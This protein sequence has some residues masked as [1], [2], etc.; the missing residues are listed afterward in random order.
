DFQELWF[1]RLDKES[2]EKIGTFYLPKWLN[3]YIESRTQRGWVPAFR[4]DYG[5]MMDWAKKGWIQPSRNLICFLLPTFLYQNISSTHPT[6][7]ERN[8]QKLLQYPETLQKHIWFFFEEESDVYWNSYYLRFKDEKDAGWLNAFVELTK[9]GHIPRERLLKSCLTATQLNVNQRLVNWYI[10]L[11]SALKPTEKE[12]L[13]LQQEMFLVLSIAHSKPKNYVVSQVKKI[14][15]KAD[16]KVLTFLDY[17]PG[18]ITSETKSLVNATLMVLEKISDKHPEY[19]SKICMLMVG[20]FIQTDSSLQARAAKFILKYGRPEDE[21]LKSELSLYLPEISSES[22]KLLADFVSEA[23]QEVLPEDV[24]LKLFKKPV[25]TPEN[26]IQI[27]QTVEELIFLTSQ[28]FENQDILD[29]ELLPAALVHLSGEIKA[30]HLPQLEPAFQRACKLT[31]SIVNKS[32]IDDLLARFFINWVR[33]MAGRFPLQKTNLDKVWKKYFEG[34]FFLPGNWGQGSPSAD[35]AFDW[36]F[37]TQSPLYNYWYQRFG[38]VFYL[39]AHNYSLPLL[40]TPTHREGW[41]DPKILIERIKAWQAE[42]KPLMHI[43]FQ[44]AITRL[45]LPG[46]E[47]YLDLVKEEIKGEVQRILCFLFNQ[48]TEPEG[49]F[50]DIAQWWTAGIT[51]NPQQIYDD[52]KD[53]I[54]TKDPRSIFTGDFEWEIQTHIRDKRYNSS[55]KSWEDGE[56]TF[57]YLNIKLPPEPKDSTLIGRLFSRSKRPSHG[58]EAIIYEDIHPMEYYV[59]AYEDDI[60]RSLNLVPNNPEKLLA[61]MAKEALKHAEFWEAHSKSLLLKTLEYLQNYS[62]PLGKMG[63]L[64]V[65]GSMVC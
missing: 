48:G 37:A 64:V 7:Y 21:A 63:H 5:W 28:A 33:M 22:R 43:D 62:K 31:Q 12:L 17:V 15:T 1:D 23:P 41:I 55:T 34:S 6:V 8:N 42:S 51:K 58:R 56:S 10:D 53:F 25:L 46:A 16:F 45:W 27:P 52:F 29:V 61:L 4:M 20:T 49:P 54:Y 65:A 50:E 57:R 60:Q 24:V 19:V 11:F 38:E 3:E 36:R 39:L 30:E 44:L 18:L 35:V 14:C 32:L 59:V 13:Q 26:A 9:E 2:L 40:S 47:K